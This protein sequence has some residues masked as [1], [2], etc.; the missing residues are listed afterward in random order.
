MSVIT[1]LTKNV[2]V[3]PFYAVVGVTDL[4]VE[5]ARE[6]A[7]VAEARAT[8]AR[9]DFDKIV[10]DLAPAKVQERAIATFTQVQTQVQELPNTVAAERKANADKLVAGYEDLAVRGK[11]L[12]ERIRNQ[13]ATQDFVAQAETTVAQAKGAV[14]TA[15]K[16][17]ADVER[18]AKATVTTARK[19]AVKAAEAIAASVTDEV[20][21]AEAEV[22]GAVKRTRTAAKR[23]TT[24]TRNAAKKTTASAKGVR[25][26][27]KK[28]AAAAEKATT[29]AAAKVGD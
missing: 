7:V 2:D 15:R 16:A 27:A 3:R 5:K 10:A 14:T 1:D 24:T 19:E 18:S 12:I 23:T 29:K 17:A 22:T 21:T 11:K 20:K 25:T 4:T 13:K 6:A 26:T 9:A 28:T 8:K